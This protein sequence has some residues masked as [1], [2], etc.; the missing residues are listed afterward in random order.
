[1]H[2]FLV[3]EDTPHN[4]R[5][6]EQIIEELDE[7]IQVVKAYSGKDALFLCEETSYDLILMDISMP[8]IDGIHI[9]KL[10]RQYSQLQDTPI[11]AVTAY[12]M[13]SEE[14]TFREIFDD[15]VSK[16][17]DEEQLLMTM[18]K[19]MEGNSCGS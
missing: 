1:M 11:I 5:L 16:P 7:S 14:E 2:K 3:V 4:M 9:T 19:W 12:A 13:S 6:I 15:Y 8:D 17:I 10:L 18:K